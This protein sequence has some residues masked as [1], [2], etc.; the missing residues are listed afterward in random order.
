MNKPL[1]DPPPVN[2]KAPTRR[3]FARWRLFFERSTRSGQNS[4][5]IAPEDVLTADHAPARDFDHAKV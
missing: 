4:R 1:L 3:D 2:L 5:P